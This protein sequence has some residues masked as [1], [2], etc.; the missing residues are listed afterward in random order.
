MIYNELEN[1]DNLISTLINLPPNLN[2]VRVEII[3]TMLRSL[4]Y[5]VKGIKLPSL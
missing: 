2:K 5:Y 4:S 3:L 1:I